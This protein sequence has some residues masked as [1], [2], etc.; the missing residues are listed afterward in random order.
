MAHQ[1]KPEGSAVG[2]GGDRLVDVGRAATSVVG[3]E[4]GLGRMCGV[5]VGVLLT[6]LIAP[7]VEPRP[8][9]NDDGPCSTSTSSRSNGVAIIA[10]EVAHAVEIEI[11]ASIESAQCQVRALS[12]R[13]AAPQA[14]P[15]ALRKTS[16]R[17][18]APRSSIT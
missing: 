17:L 16:G 7:P 18:V 3:A 1:H 4:V 13:L 15:D 9:S 2:Q 11:V 8:N 6:W 5:S 10:A 14:D 12:T